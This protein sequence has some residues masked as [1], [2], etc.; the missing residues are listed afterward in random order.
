VTGIVVVVLQLTCDPVICQIVASI[1]VEMP[2]SSALLS[3]GILKVMRWVQDCCVPIAL[4][5]VGRITCTPFWM[6]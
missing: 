2:E 4:M 5:F 3:S 1:K 6:W